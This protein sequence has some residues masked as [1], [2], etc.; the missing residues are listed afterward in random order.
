[1]SSPSVVAPAPSK[2]SRHAVG[3]VLLVVF[4][5]MVGLGL[6]LPVLPELIETVGHM[7]LDQAARIGG[8]MFAAFSLAQFLFAPMMGALSD[9]FGRR[10]LLLI[11]VAGLGVDYL[12]HALAPTVGWLFVGRVIAGVCGASHVIANAYLADITPPEG[13]ARAFGLMGAAFGLGF[14]LGPAIGGLLGEL[15]PRVPFWVAAGISA[16]NFLYGLFVLPESLPQD[17]RRAFRLR[18]ANPLGVLEVFARYKGVLPLAA[19]FSVY[20]F[21]SAVYPAIWSFWG[22]AKFG[23]SEAMVGV[24]LA[25]FG[26][27][28][29]LFQGVLTGPAVR[30]WGEPRAALIGLIIGVVVCAGYGMAT[31]IV[32]VVVLLF[33]HGPEGFVHPMLSAMMSRAVPEDAQGALQGGLS[34]AMNLMMLLGTLFFTQVFGYFLSEAAPV[35][36]PDAAYFVAAGV[37]GLALVLYLPQ[38]RRLRDA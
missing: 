9:R 11:A 15:G 10:P 27:V 22:M 12:F 23:W 13:R 31:G 1:M 4:L 30:L 24:S 16:A 17:R 19:V 26:I 2:P 32:A 34:G 37:L 6:I 28:W 21:G 33:I 3:F 14:V 38:W 25:A 8:L 36:T 20:F 7:T 29:A 5:D 35:R 18:E